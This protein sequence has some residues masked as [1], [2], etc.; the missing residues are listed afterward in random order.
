MAD[1]GQRVLGALADW[2]FWVVPLIILYILA[3][4]AGSFFIAAIGWLWSIAASVYLAI[5]LGQ[6]GSTPGMRLIG[7]K[8]IS[9]T[10]GQP[11]GAGMGVVR[12]IAHFVD[13]II[14]YI[15]WLFPLWDSQRQTL[16][17]KI[18]GTVVIKVP[19]E[20]FSITPKTT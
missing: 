13:S 1:W 12:A 18:I 20:G 8:C 9:K 3:G 16:A 11:I 15:G 7:L 14:C 19:A 10:T 17:D 5:Q 2:V 6:Y 4:I